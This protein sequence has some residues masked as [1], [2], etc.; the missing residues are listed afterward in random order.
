MALHAPVSGSSLSSTVRLTTTP[1]E[2]SSTYAS[3][4]YRTRTDTSPRVSRMNRGR[5]NLF[6]FGLFRTSTDRAL[7]PCAW[8]YTHHG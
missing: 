5:Q 4:C 7:L 8:R 1:V 2:P 3:N 6:H